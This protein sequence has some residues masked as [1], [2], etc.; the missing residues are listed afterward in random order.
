MRKGRKMI[1]LVDLG[2]FSCLYW[3]NLITIDNVKIG[4]IIHN[5][6]ILLLHDFT[7]EVVQELERPYNCKHVL[8]R[9]GGVLLLTDRFRAHQA[10][11]FALIRPLTVSRLLS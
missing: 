6:T 10:T 9:C 11:G 5:F 7:I 1:F 2:D 8:C 4:I 3:Y